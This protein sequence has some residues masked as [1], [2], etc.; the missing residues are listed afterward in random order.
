VITPL[1][2]VSRDADGDN[3]TAAKF[4]KIFNKVRGMIP[5]KFDAESRIE[6]GDE[7]FSPST[8]HLRSISRD[9]HSTRV[10]LEPPTTTR[11]AR[12]RRTLLVRRLITLAVSQRV[13]VTGGCECGCGGRI[14]VGLVNVHAVDYA[15]TRAVRG[16]LIRVGLVVAPVITHGIP[17]RIIIRGVIRGHVRR[18]RTSHQK[19]CDD[20]YTEQREQ[21]CWPAVFSLAFCYSFHRIM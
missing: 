4:L 21:H 7:N 9:E 6:Y 14:R 20:A 8:Y 3:M 5:L 10:L 18:F 11:K 12:D 15:V 1:A 19:S 16:I 17:G 2:L 13:S